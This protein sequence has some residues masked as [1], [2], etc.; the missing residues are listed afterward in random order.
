MAEVEAIYAFVQ[1]LS[2]SNAMISPD[3]MSVGRCSIDTK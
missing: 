1:K 2:S 3:T